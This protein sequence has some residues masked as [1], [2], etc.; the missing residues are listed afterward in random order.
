MSD[1]DSTHWSQERYITPH[2][3]DAIE[4]RWI[5]TGDPLLL[6]ADE[7]SHSEELCERLFMSEHEAFNTG[8]AIGEARRAKDVPGGGDD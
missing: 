8:R 4:H 6:P 1:S 7:L 3:F 2:W 5:E